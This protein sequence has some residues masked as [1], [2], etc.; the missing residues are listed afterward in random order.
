VARKPV[1]VLDTNVFVSGLL[2]PNGVPGVILQRFREE[3]FSIATSRAQVRE[4]HDV[5]GRPSLAK[6]L[7]KGTPREVL[8][9]FARFKKLTDVYA[10]P[11]LP[12]DLGDRDDHFLLDL[13]VYS[14]AQFLVTGDKA[15]RGLLLVGSCAVVTP[16]EFV[17]R[18]Q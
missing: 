13:A 10:P 12:W 4:I 5:L 8:R 14:K 2:S 15:L 18:V 9:F 7:P 11:K 6:A 17:A 3:R 16:I 1:V